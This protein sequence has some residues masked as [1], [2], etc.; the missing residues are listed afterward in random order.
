MKDFRFKGG[1]LVIEDNDL[2]LAHDLDEIAQ[3]IE[4]TL[5][6]NLGEFVLEPGLGI[7]YMNM[8]G[9]DVTEEDVQAEIFAGLDQE[10][11]IVQVNDIMVDFD[12]STRKA[13]ARFSAT[14]ETGE[15]I[16]SEVNLNVG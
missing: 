5:G 11:R 2:V 4:S 16:E 7:T 13:K 15:V 6:T 8:L 14:A 1:D 12:T 9:K 10:E 3:S